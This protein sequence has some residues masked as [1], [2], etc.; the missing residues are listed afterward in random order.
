MTLD[1][2][3]KIKTS[4]KEAGFTQED[5]ADGI[6]VSRQ[7]I[8]SW[9]N[10]KSYPDIISVIKMS[11]IYN[12]SLDYLL[13]GEKN[14]SNYYNYLEEST[15]VVK[16]NTKKEKLILIASYIVVWAIAMVT[17][18]FFNAAEDA[19]GYSLMYLWIILPVTTLVVSFFIG[20][21]D[22]WGKAK[23]IAAPILGIMY[24]LAEYGTFSMANNVA[25]GK[26]NPPEWKM[27]VIDIAIS[28][29]GIGIG[30]LL[31]RKKK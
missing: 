21:Y 16:S 18:W 19:M 8:L 20:K 9:E 15:N 30:T 14:M 1:I 26:I 5:A 27:I 24:M 23:W 3:E 13:K 28:I 11:D 31:S 2:G 10:N 29:M 6:G 22:M 7:T 25:F 12:V 4:R 17:F